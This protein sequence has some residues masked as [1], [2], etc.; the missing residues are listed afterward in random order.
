M[1]KIRTSKATKGLN[2]FESQ[3]LPAVEQT[4]RDNRQDFTFSDKEMEELGKSI[5]A[6]IELQAS[7][8]EFEKE[9]RKKKEAEKANREIQAELTKGGAIQALG[10]FWD[11]LTTGND[12]SKYYMMQNGK[13]LRRKDNTNFFEDV[14]NVATSMFTNPLAG[15]NEED[16]T[17]NEDWEEVSPEEVSKFIQ[18]QAAKRHHSNAFHS[19]F[20][21]ASFFNGAYKMAT[22]DA[23]TG[24]ASIFNNDLS[25][26]AKQVQST[27][28]GINAKLNTIEMQ[29]LEKVGLKN[30]SY[31]KYL[32]QGNKDIYKG[33]ANISNSIKEEQKKR[34]KDIAENG[35]SALTQAVNYI[36]QLED[37]NKYSAQQ[38]QIRQLISQT[39]VSLSGEEK[40]EFL[41]EDQAGVIDPTIVNFNGNDIPMEYTEGSKWDAKRLV[42][43]N[44]G[45]PMLD[46]QGN[47]VYEDKYSLM[48]KLSKAS[49]G[50][51][52]TKYGSEDLINAASSSVGFLAGGY[53]SSALTRG[54]G[55]TIGKGVSYAG[56]VGNISERG[57][58]MLETV[59]NKLDDLMP[60][61][62]K[63]GGSM[64]VA[65]RAANSFNKAFQTT[66]NSYVMTNSESQLIGEQTAKEV[67]EK[68]I[69][70]LA[71]IDR[72]QLYQDILQENPGLNETEAQLKL[73]ATVASIR[74]E[75]AK[76]N[77]DANND[78]I[79]LSLAA[80]ETAS[81]LN[82]MNTLF[83]LNFG[84]AFAK[85]RSLSRNILSSPYSGRSIASGIY[86]TLGEG[87]QEYFEEGLFN[88]YAQKAATE[89]AE[90]KNLSILDFV[91]NDFITKENVTSGLIGMIS[92]LGQSTLMSGLGSFSKY[93]EYKKQQKNIQ[94]FKS[95]A[96]SKP[97]DLKSVLELALDAKDFTEF[98]IQ[99]D[100]YGAEIE[101][102][103]REGKK[104]EAEKKKEELKGLTENLL[105]N[106]AIRAAHMGTS[107]KLSDALTELSKNEEFTEDQRKNFAE[108]VE[109]N[110]MIA[111]MHDKYLYYHGSSAIMQNRVNKFMVNKNLKDFQTKYGATVASQYDNVL[112][113]ET[114]K[115]MASSGLT[116]E[117][118]EYSPAFDQLRSR[119]K[120][121]PAT[122][123]AVE[124]KILYD[125]RIAEVNELLNKLDEQY[126]ELTSRKGQQELANKKKE[127]LKKA[128]VDSTT[129]ENVQEVKE[130]IKKEEGKLTGETV[131]KIEN[132]AYAKQVQVPSPNINTGFNK[133]NA[134]VI[135][136]TTPTPKAVEVKAEE[137]PVENVVNSS[138]D[139]DYYMNI[140]NSAGAVPTDQELSDDNDESSVTRFAPVITYNKDDE[141]QNQMI[142]SLAEAFKKDL[143]LNPTL[144]LDAVIARFAMDKGFFKVGQYFDL[145]VESWGK[146]TGK[147]LT[148]VEKK[149]LYNQYFGV[150][151]ALGVF[152]ELTNTPTVVG[153][154]QTNANVVPETIPSPETETTQTPVIE[155]Q[156]TP[157]LAEGIN[158]NTNPQEDQEVNPVKAVRGL[159][160]AESDAKLAFLGLQYNVSPDGQT[161]TTSTTTI[162]ESAK[163]FL[164]PRNF[165]PGDTFDISFNFN[166]LL[167][168]SNTVRV[169]IENNIGEY[170][171]KL[172]TVEER[173]KQIFPDMSFTEFARRLQTD[174]RSLLENDTFLKM[175]PVGIIFENEL[176]EGGLNDYDWWNPRNI[177]ETIDPKTRELIPYSQNKIIL[178]GRKKNLE[179][180]QSLLNSENFTSNIEITANT[181]AFYNK[182]LLVTEKEIS[183]GYSDEY[184]SVLDAFN[185]DLDY[186]EKNVALG[187]FNNGNI[188]TEKKNGNKVLMIGGKQVSPEQIENLV[189][190]KDA[191]LKEA[192][193]NGQVAYNPDSGRRVMLAKSGYENGK[194][195]YTAH[196]VTT[197]H[198]AKQEEFKKIN[199]LLNRLV[200]T[201]PIQG[202]AKYLPSYAW[203]LQNLGNAEALAEYPAITAEYIET[204]K[205]VKKIFLDK[206]KIDLT[207][208]SH[209]SD[210]FRN[211]YP[212]RNPNKKE[213]FTQNINSFARPM[214]KNGIPDLTALFEGNGTITEALNKI[215]SGNIDFITPQQ[216]YAKNSHTQYIFTPFDKDGDIIYSN[217][218]QKKISFR[219]TGSAT[220]DN[221]ENVLNKKLEDAKNQLEFLKEG[222]EKRPNDETLKE[223]LEIVQEQV[224]NLE[225]KVEEEKKSEEVLPVKPVS[226]ISSSNEVSNTSIKEGVKELF[227]ENPELASIGTQ[228]QYSQYLDTIFPD[229]QVKDIVYHGTPYGKFESFNKE[230]LHT[231]DKSSIGYY[232][233]GNK[234]KVSR[235]LKGSFKNG[236]QPYVVNALVNV[237][238][239]SSQNFDYISIDEA[240][241]TIEKLKDFITEQDY[242]NVVANIKSKD[243]IVYAQL[244]KEIIYDRE[245]QIE[246]ENEN[247]DDDIKV[248]HKSDDFVK[249][250]IEVT[251]I[252]SFYQGKTIFETDASQLVLLLSEQIHILGS[253]SDIQGFKEF[254]N[255]STSRTIEQTTQEFTESDINDINNEVFFKALSRIDINNFSKASILEQAT[256]VFE[257]TVRDLKSNGL[258]AEA[259]FMVS[260]KN[261]I[262]G[263]GTYDGSVK[264]VIDVTFDI[265]IETEFA[266]EEQGT[267]NLTSENS[268]DYTKESFEK[269]I[270]TSLGMKVKAILSGITDTRFTDNTF[271]NFRQTLPLNETLDFLQQALAE[272][273]NNTLEALGKTIKRKIDKNPKDFG[274]YQEIFDRLNNKELIDSGVINEILYNLYQAKLDMNMLFYSINSD[275]QFT[276][277]NYDANSKSPL[278]VKRN[279]W[280]ENLKMSSLINRYEEGYYTV[281]KDEANRLLNLRDE[282]NRTAKEGVV[283]T[284][285]LEDFLNGF[286]IS[287]N[288]MTIDSLLQQ[289]LPE[290]VGGNLTTDGFILREK[291]L[292]SILADNIDKALKHQEDKKKLALS[293]EYV[294]NEKTILFDLLTNDNS[295]NLNTMIAYDNLLS[296]ISMTS[297]YVG[298][299]IVNAYTAPNQI[300]NTVK[301]LKNDP[302]I[303]YG[304]DSK[305]KSYFNILEQTPMTQDSLILE[306]IKNEPRFKSYFDVVNVSLEALK[307]RG[308]KSRTDRD[309][310]SL[311]DKDEFITMFN[312]FSHIDGEITND[313]YSDRFGRLKFRRGTIGFPALSDSSQKPL[314]KTAL[315]NLRTEDFTD[316]TITR[317]SDNVLDFVKTH[318]VTPNLKRIEQY[319]KSGKN[320]NVFGHNVGAMFMTDMPSLNYMGLTINLD[321][322]GNLNETGEPTVLPAIE[323][324]KLY[325]SQGKTI[326][327]FLEDYNTEINNEVHRNL[328]FEVNQYIDEKGETGLLVEEGIFDGQNINFIDQ[329]Y[330]NSPDRK[331]SSNLNKARLMMYDYVINYMVNQKEIQVLF[332]GDIANFFKDK[333]QSNFSDYKNSF[334]ISTEDIIN[335]Y[336]NTPGQKERINS[337]ISSGATS[338]IA[339]EFPLLRG[340]SELFPEINPNE[341]LAINLP[342]QQVKFNTL[343][344]DVQNNLSKRLKALLSPGQQSPDSTG[345]KK[346]LQVMVQ[347]VESAS[348]VLIPMAILKYPELAEDNDFKIKVLEFKE[349]DDILEVQ[350]TPEQQKRY[351]DLLKEFNRKYPLIA[352]FFKN[353]TTDAQEYTTWKENL[354]QLRSQGRITQEDY[355]TYYSKFTDQVK[356]G[357]TAENELSLEDMQKLV[358][359]PT[360][361][362]QTGLYYEENSGYHYQRLVYV[363]S[364]SFPL[365]PQLTRSFPK[366]D[367]LRKNL[368]SLETDDRTVRMSYA[369]ANKVGA[370]IGEGISIAALYKEDGLTEEDK[371][372]ILNTSSLELDRGSFYIQ[373][374]KPFKS[375]KNAKAGKVDRNSR[376]T[377]FEKI[378]LGDGISKIK[379]QIFPSRFSKEILDSLNIKA[380][381]GKVSGVE[382]QKIYNELYKRE[383]KLL[384]KKLYRQ[385]GIERTG[386]MMSGNPKSMRKLVS[387]LNKRLN[388][389]QDRQALELVYYGRDSQGNTTK[390]TQKSL[391]ESGHSDIFKAEF[392]IPLYMTPNSKKFE[393]VLNSVVN[394]ALINLTLPGFSSPVA[395]QQGFDIKGYDAETTYP[396]LITTP[397]FNPKKGL[398]ATV[399]SETGELKHAQVFAASKYKVLNETTGEYE[400][401]DLKNYVD[402]NNVLDTNKLP[403]ELLE[404]FSFRIPTSAHQSGIVIEIVGFL[405]HTV[406]DMLVVPKDHTTQIGEDYDIDVRYMYQLNYIQDEN[407]NL[408]AID[409]DDFTLPKS[410]EEIRNE[411][412]AFRDQLFNEFFTINTTNGI[413]N[414]KTYLNNPYWRNNQE[415]L[416]EMYFIQDTLEARNLTQDMLSGINR[417]FNVQFSDELLETEDE[418]NSTDAL[419]ERLAELESQLIPTE[420]VKE[421]GRQMREE[422]KDVKK[423]L[424]QAFK[425][426]E[427]EAKRLMNDYALAIKKEEHDIKVIENNI[428]NIYK[429]VFSSSNKE[430]RDLVSRVLSTDFANNTATEMDRVLSSAKDNSVYNVYSPS[431][432]R[433]IMKLGADGKM[434]IG[435]HSNAV[436]MNSI[437]QQYNS[438]ENGELR[439]Y[440][441]DPEGNRYYY[442]IVLGSLIFDGVLGKVEK[443]GKRISESGMESQNSATDNQKLQIMGR[444]NENKHTI[445]VLAILQATGNDFDG[446]I[447]DDKEMSYASLFINQPIIRD[448]VKLMNKYGS[449][450]SK[451]KGDINEQVDKDLFEKW[452]KHLP[453][454][455]WSLTREGKNTRR[456]NAEAVDNI[457]P[458]ITGENLY[459]SLLEEEAFKADNPASQWY[460][461]QSFL[462]LKGLASHYNR[463]QRF[464][465]IESGGL[466][467]SYFDTIELMKE[468]ITLVNPLS[469]EVRIENSNKLFGDYVRIEPIAEVLT[470]DENTN[471]ILSAM[472][473]EEDMFGNLVDEN[474]KIVEENTSTRKVV[475][476]RSIEEF[477]KK[478]Q[479]YESMGYIKV[480]L[481]NSNTAH[482][483]SPQNHYAHKIINSITTG[484][485][486]WNSI[487]PYDHTFVNQI[488][489]DIQNSAKRLTNDESLDLKYRVI[490]E[491]KDYIYSNSLD[492]FEGNVEKYRKDLFFDYNNDGVENESLAT[493]LLNLSNNPNFKNRLFKQ[494][495][496]KDL[497]FDINKDTY[498]STIRYN[499]SDVSKGYNLS[500]YN[501]FEKLIDSKTELPDYNGKPYTYELLMKDILRY[502]LLADQG[503]GAIGFRHLLPMSLL[504]KYG[505]SDSVKLQTDIKNQNI[506]NIV[507][508]GIEKAVSNFFG[509]ELTNAEDVVKNNNLKSFDKVSSFVKMVNKK[510]ANEYG[511][512][513][514]ISILNELGDVKINIIPDR[515]VKSTFVRQFFQHNP[516]YANTIGTIYRGNM[517]PSATKK[518]KN[519][520]EDNGYTPSLDITKVNSLHIKHDY[521]VFDDFITISDLSGKRILFERVNEDGLYIP[522]PTL[523]V[524]GYNEYSVGKYLDRS[525]V[526]KNN[527]TRT[528]DGKI[529]NSKTLDYI[530]NTSLSEIVKDI[531]NSSGPYQEAF[532]FLSPYVDLKNQKIKVVDAN[533]TAFYQNGTIFINR[534]WLENEDITKKELQEKILEELIHR[535][536]E[537]TIDTYVDITG[538]DENGQLMIEYKMSDIPNDLK[539]LLDVYQKAIDY[540]INKYGLEQF[541]ASVRKNDGH[542]IN[543][544][545][546]NPD[547]TVAKGLAMYRASN[548]HE[549]VAGMFLRDE[550][551]AR[552]M[553]TVEYGKTSDTILERFASR[554]VR[555]LN[556]V[557]N[558]FKNNNSINKAT[559]TSFYS[560][561]TRNYKEIDNSEFNP[562][563]PT[564]A[565]IQGQQFLQDN[566]PTIEPD[567]LSASELAALQQFQED[568]SGDQV[569][570]LPSNIKSLVEIS[571]E[572]TTPQ[573]ETAK[574]VKSDVREVALSFN[575]EFSAYD[576]YKAQTVKIPGYKAWFGVIKLSN[577]NVALVTDV[578]PSNQGGDVVLLNNNL[579]PDAQGLY[580]IEIKRFV[581]EMV[582]NSTN[583][584][585]V[586]KLKG[587]NKT[588]N[589]FAGSNENAELSNFAT[590]PFRADLDSFFGTR[591][592]GTRGEFLYEPNS[593]YGNTF[594][595]VEHAFQALKFHYL[596]NHSN[597]P[598]VNSENIEQYE[599]LV[600]EIINAETPAKAKQLGRKIKLSQEQ[601]KFWDNVSSKFMKTLI[602]FS[603]E[604]NPNSLQTL[605]NTGD[606][607]LTHNQD[608]TKWKTEFPRILMELRE[609]FR[610]SRT[611]NAPDVRKLV[612]GNDNLSN[613]ED[614]TKC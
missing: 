395:S 164:D 270:K 316:G 162:N 582:S 17:Y 566:L 186:F 314:L 14:S 558:V 160:N 355:D 259:D 184:Q 187:F 294:T 121:D 342:L 378:I 440:S 95:L 570:E 603:F 27:A 232:F 321:S 40:P 488:I 80:K 364:S 540:V 483:V 376:A 386:D 602:Q 4:I 23:V 123:K 72:D 426:E 143:A 538:F 178:D 413:S 89:F 226:Q 137:I 138:E 73:E 46:D 130:T 83:N 147:P 346:Y 548:I 371:D 188:F 100:A 525:N 322:S 107:Q 390:G 250:F 12:A 482:M 248:F 591:K 336:Y 330:I 59:T 534:N 273:E 204:A 236:T 82:N 416:W 312:L 179:I 379:E 567:G 311:S 302:E 7:L 405:P 213:E 8:E 224:K 134:T 200:A 34:A 177:A 341:R 515:T 275:G 423:D 503:N 539:D 343:M 41:N 18:T 24:V 104:E 52:F 613:F 351:N 431:S 280:K 122:N 356:N 327:D 1:A 20:A 243:K 513:N 484:Y 614:I 580:G 261:N 397:N 279:K 176:L 572:E 563:M 45:Q 361:P 394:K 9:E 434:G 531:Y 295:N 115:Q 133:N 214:H 202:D 578:F 152:G 221:V 317:L 161:Y 550:V 476:P 247:E 598:E 252:D 241:E 612:E 44:S 492:L 469:T 125:N 57:L 197:N 491:L 385:L 489:N 10:N 75:F 190:I 427:R 198:S 55:S 496:F 29:A 256:I 422:F 439:F 419:R 374:D 358:M 421:K 90:G 583:P 373:Q 265:P 61:L 504:D 556:S 257:E 501:I 433:S 564:P 610:N 518:L 535:I 529:N 305:L 290:V 54:I 245:K 472:Q 26:T 326:E 350:R 193:A 150:D 474:G 414:T 145:I 552:E 96:E 94:E 309:I 486:L 246:Y 68:K 365:V 406:G 601:I 417:I 560:F 22:K 203:V 212:T 154:T 541:L 296:A 66:L 565:L 97:E 384:K 589:I 208:N 561:L 124:N 458:R 244:L 559:I 588:I 110:E 263:I 301:R 369:S 352:P 266:E 368:E 32:E 58:R 340:S 344:K 306:M 551:F 475:T 505:V 126:Y 446:F 21:I 155:G 332:A 292:V 219:L 139:L 348:E 382:L 471:E 141:S 106:K 600:D 402:E 156:S 487:F 2:R 387:L 372:L 201:N 451:F 249:K 318:L 366:L 464:V 573:V 521:D 180:R 288:E 238:N 307:E 98:K 234:D 468:L 604:Q 594:K 586:K 522:I 205:A 173:I 512:T 455:Y 506:Q 277:K 168:P 13:Y 533:G 282:I 479:Q 70:K 30:T 114:S 545:N 149:S 398:Q 609:E 425:R 128:V 554:L 555:L 50:N 142:N 47:P 510:I 569:E 375:D 363:K 459:G 111:D 271:A 284:R 56:K 557:V 303:P 53:T 229:S 211:F 393:S 116:V 158:V 547:E 315:V 544:D 195:I 293:S 33:V 255:S 289:N 456:L 231:G 473:V 169:W 577:G 411:Y 517:M 181:S 576:T 108:A 392:K 77:P 581:D 349:I 608:S 92:G 86:H 174:P 42:L 587:E 299:K 325:I 448:Y 579:Q 323:V 438:E 462:Q 132:K 159:L 49:I 324:F 445:N 43:D 239:P 103:E 337:L 347:D 409:Y 230:N 493:Y 380:E 319:I 412:N 593:N 441:V 199:S 194:P 113:L 85:G 207:K 235:Y 146:A 51:L 568:T 511:I 291:G 136:E 298:G 404:L 84:A 38:E 478:I 442:D 367:A 274:F 129:T 310:T 163:V 36:T 78:A 415:I 209:I 432:Q 117:D 597:A 76:N 11:G 450:T 135:D 530:E 508:N 223:S 452:G 254:I 64:A 454:T 399:D 15:I 151:N 599:N 225:V 465:N 549:F 537:E 227:N 449:S 607:T 196:L 585:N 611:L 63:Q 328:D 334:P 408:K 596:L 457:A 391:I 443:N 118:A 172:L 218:A 127:A 183:Q 285:A 192:E 222:L 228:E 153:N 353:A 499:T 3:D 131:D 297:I 435:V 463:L 407:G 526:N 575:E 495:F 370:P 93:N 278:I 606:A 359:Q 592:G 436:T 191:I 210:G 418:T 185:N 16:G 542:I 362:L 215:V 120:I 401:I 240:L 81:S 430:V 389:K 281:N 65:N 523:G 331:T 206:F 286:G 571:S 516:D 470:L 461:Y 553:D 339:N 102:L 112:D 500:V 269:D 48:D 105:V 88:S 157:E 170:E 242:N 69:D 25:T 109:L 345:N 377:Q 31:Y 444:R 605:L 502:S 37:N 410:V 403:Q 381:D 220:N 562:E 62:S 237:K 396:G 39:A 466:G 272:S 485:E 217:L 536:T 428:V 360:K 509:S 35:E 357:V 276:A 584:E 166:Y 268:K 74:S 546:N 532:K 574:I 253:Q 267:V 144:P 87:V 60:S 233:L 182:L 354:N 460:T 497:V 304:K 590:R 260:N 5:Q 19:G 467:V 498:P 165:N 519:I 258:E 283:N 335:H 171:G 528:V 300:S 437:L 507:F 383:Q 251:N 264:E 595:T 313:D 524:F 329:A 490:S 320:V 91:D 420:L 453:K 101:K 338:L 429:S 424:Y 494:N 6:D 79:A 99:Q 148:S 71:N 262:L 388:N 189:A 140:M 480:Q 287:L 481:S 216:L 175:V 514:A 527:V 333:H 477:N 67:Y 308:T 447:L 167:N 400:Y 520:L 119:I 28:L 543:V